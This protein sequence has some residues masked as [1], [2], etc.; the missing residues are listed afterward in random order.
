MMGESTQIYCINGSWSDS[1][2]V[3]CAF[4]A[5]ETPNIT[6]NNETTTIAVHETSK[7][8]SEESSGN[9][10]VIIICIVVLVLVVM[11]IIGV[12]LFR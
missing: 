1:D 10:D 8:Q 2:N 4:P 11:V 9:R 7:I 12:V 6:Y 3:R 5:K